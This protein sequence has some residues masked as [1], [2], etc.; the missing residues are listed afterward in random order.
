MDIPYISR[1][2][3]GNLEGVT[4]GRT[5][6]RFCS[7]QQFQAL[8]LLPRNRY[9]SIFL[10][11]LSAGDSHDIVTVITLKSRKISQN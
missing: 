6:Q 10:S 7:R 8:L 11:E 1:R 3:G 9:D 2:R 5:V 4:L